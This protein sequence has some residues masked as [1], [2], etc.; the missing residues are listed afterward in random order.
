MLRPAREKC[1]PLKK[2]WELFPTSTSIHC[3]STRDRDRNRCCIFYQFYYSALNALQ[4][5][6]II[7]GIVGSCLST[8]LKTDH[9]HPGEIHLVLYAN[10]IY[11]QTSIN[12]AIISEFQC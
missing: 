6:L 3:S 11:H 8:L 7:M 12:I 2:T 4:V 10:V 9:R 5:A 1:F